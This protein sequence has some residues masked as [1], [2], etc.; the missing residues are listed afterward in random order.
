MHTH[1][2]Y[3]LVV[4]IQVCKYLYQMHLCQCYFY[5]GSRT[6]W[7]NA[8]YSLIYLPNNMSKHISCD[9]SNF[10]E[11][12]FLKYGLMIL[13]IS[14]ICCYIS[15]FTSDCVYLDILCIFSWVWIRLNLDDFLKESTHWYT[16]SLYCFLCFDF[17][18]L[19]LQFGCFLHLLFYLFL[20]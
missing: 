5:M 13:W 20:L 4:L 10:V 14:C 17:V 2:L 1:S 12:S 9:F 7:N 16:D 15:L 18:D 6:G 3:I 19:I 11:C 8:S